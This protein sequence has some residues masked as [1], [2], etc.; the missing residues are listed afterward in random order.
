MNGPIQAVICDLGGVLT[1]PLMPAFL[2][3][4]QRA[5]LP[6]DALGRAMA[7]VTAADGANPLFEIECGRMTMLDFETRLGAALTGD[8]GR[9][10]SMDDFSAQ[11]WRALGPNPPM[12]ELMVVLRDEGYR[13]AMLTNN[14]VE[15]GPH[16]RALLPVDEIFELVV[17]SAY[18]GMRK[19]DPAIYELTLG[20]LDVPAERCLFIDDFEHNCAAAAALGMAAVVYRD[21][22]QAIAEIRAQL[23]EPSRSQM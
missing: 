14:V 8:L 16:W 23:L 21:A 11:M 20:R 4:Q 3:I 5:G 10:V 1:T 7:T 13:M 18:V 17:D 15:W 12:I 19:P 6:L 2:K 22:E 9:A